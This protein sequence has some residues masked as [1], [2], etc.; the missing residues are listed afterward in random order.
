MNFISTLNRY[1]KVKFLWY[2]G[3]NIAATIDDDDDDDDGGGGGGDDGGGDDGTDDDDDYDDDD[4]GVYDDMIYECINTHIISI[5]H[6]RQCQD[7]QH[8]N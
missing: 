6:T 4:D 2:F 1:L 7:V 3:L 5:L 8:S